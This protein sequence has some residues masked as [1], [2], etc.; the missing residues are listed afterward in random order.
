MDF[1][2]AAGHNK[3]S[4]KYVSTVRDH[5]FMTPKVREYADIVYA[6]P[7]ADKKKFE[8]PTSSGS[9]NGHGFS[10]SVDVAWDY[11]AKG[12]VSENLETD[13]A[14][15]F[16]AIVK[17]EVPASSAS[18][19]HRKSGGVPHKLVVETPVFAVYPSDISDVNPVTA[20]SDVNG[21]KAVA[22]VR[23][24]NLQGMEHN[25]PWEGINIVVTTY[26]D[27]SRTTRK[28]IR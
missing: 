3:V 2:T 24:Y 15:V 25:Q 28:A 18:G 22:G 26:S 5:F 13:K 19:T 7:S 16:K 9:V 14:Y 23:Y 12:D 10:G 4:G 6:V 20:V 17:C 8:I 27:G 1:T 11:N 21:E